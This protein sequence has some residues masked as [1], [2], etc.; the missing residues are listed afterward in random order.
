MHCNRIVTSR[1]GVPQGL[2][3]GPLFLLLYINNLSKIISDNSNPVL[4]A[5]DTS[6]IIT[7]SNPLAFRNDINEVLGK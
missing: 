7:N 6:I 5:N 4:F 3:L 2:I 1:H